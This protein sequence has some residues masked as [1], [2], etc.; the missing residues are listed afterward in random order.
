[1][2]A[3]LFIRCGVAA[4]LLGA[5]STVSSGSPV[6]TFMPKQ[7]L[8]DYNPS[9]SLKSCLYN[10]FKFSIQN[11]LSMTSMSRMPANVRTEHWH[12]HMHFSKM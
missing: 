8:M 9:F 7:A 3:I 2:A 6:K 12:L 5:I 1:M 11:G 4:S 10:S